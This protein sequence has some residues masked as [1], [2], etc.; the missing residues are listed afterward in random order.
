MARGLTGRTLCALSVTIAWKK[1]VFDSAM[2]NDVQNFYSRPLRYNAIRRF[3]DMRKVS[4]RLSRALATEGHTT[5]PPRSRSSRDSRWLTFSLDRVYSL[6]FVVSLEP[7]GIVFTAP[8]ILGANYLLF[9]LLSRRLRDTRT[10]GVEWVG[11]HLEY[12][13]SVSVTPNENAGRYAK[14]LQFDPRCVHN[15]RVT[16]YP[17]HRTWWCVRSSNA[18]AC[19][20]ENTPAINHGGCCSTRT[21]ARRELRKVLT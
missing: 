21:T 10:S 18:C 15:A 1:C 7:P 14:T 3:P 6:E 4:R 9:F 16:C 17:R 12:T 2:P 13:H 8:I 11:C 20:L 5:S 19:G